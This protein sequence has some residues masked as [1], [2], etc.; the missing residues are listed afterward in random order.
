MGV[1]VAGGWVRAGD[2]LRVTL[3]AGEQAPLQPV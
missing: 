2:P 3:P 1:V